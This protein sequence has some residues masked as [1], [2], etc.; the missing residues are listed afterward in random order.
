M[1]STPSK[2][3][4]SSS[5]AASPRS[6]TSCSDLAHV[7]AAPGEQVDAARTAVASGHDVAHDPHPS[8]R[9]RSTT[10]SICG[11]L[12]LVRDRVGDQARGGDG[13]LLDHLEAV[14]A[15]RRAGRGEVDDAV[16]EARQRRQLDRALDLDDLDLAAG[17]GE[18]VGGDA[19][20][21]G[22]DPDAPEAP[23]RAADRV[24]L[25]ARGDDHVAA[26]E[27]E[28]EQLVDLAL[29]ARAARPCR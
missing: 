15:Q 10:R 11:R 19:R 22:R 18:V 29:A 16:D 23:Q 6:R 25:G 26:A 24:A 14:L 21:L 2:R 9:I 17:L 7:D 1:S 28:V 5:S 8:S 20:V 13:D 4:V 3:R 12:Q 27:A